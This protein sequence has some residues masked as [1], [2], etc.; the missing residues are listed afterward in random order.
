MTETTTTENTTAPVPAGWTWK[1]DRRRAALAAVRLT[2]Q[3]GIPRQADAIQVD[4]GTQE[5]G[6]MMSTSRPRWRAA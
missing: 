2:A 3:P 6:S 4:H 1:L 5:T